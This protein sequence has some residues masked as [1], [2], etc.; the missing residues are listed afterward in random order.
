MDAR[1]LRYQVV[2]GLSPRA[3]CASAA[4]VPRA[5]TAQL[6]RHERLAFDNPQ[7]PAPLLHAGFME[8]HLQNLQRRLPHPIPNTLRRAKLSVS[9]PL[10]SAQ[11]LLLTRHLCTAVRG[12]AQI[13]T[14]TPPIPRTP[15]IQF[16]IYSSN[17]ARSS[18]PTLHPFFGIESRRNKH[19]MATSDPSVPPAV[20]ASPLVQERKPLSGVEASKR[21]AAYKAV[22]DHFDTSY[23]YVGIG[24]GSTVVYVVEAIA[25]KGRDVTS[26]MIFV[27]TYEHFFLML[28]LKY[29]HIYPFYSVLGFEECFRQFCYLA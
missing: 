11:R 10:T 23:R 25:A 3:G 7:H 20:N 21:T 26:R 27:P 16:W 12:T 29:F 6:P 15:Q 22:E 28:C 13:N 18:L 4:S 5:L 1:I 19:S 8:I 17:S 2:Q 9:K 24:S 14:T